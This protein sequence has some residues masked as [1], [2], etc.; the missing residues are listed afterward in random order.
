MTIGCTTAGAPA[1]A[2]GAAG[3]G[4]APGAGPCPGAVAEGTGRSAVAAGFAVVTG[5]GGGRCSRCHAS[6]RKS[7][8]NEK[9]MNRISRWVSMAALR[10]GEFDRAMR[11]RTGQGTGS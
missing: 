4:P 8:E 9:M 1:S 6:H 5:G 10:D 3:T 2:P 7:A 11:S